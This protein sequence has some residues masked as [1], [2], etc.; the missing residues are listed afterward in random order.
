MNT[1]I[2]EPMALSSIEKYVQADLGNDFLVTITD[3]QYQSPEHFISEARNFKHVVKRVPYIPKGFRLGVSRIFVAFFWTKEE[4]G[5]NDNQIFSYFV[6]EGIDLIIPSELDGIEEFREFAN[7]PGINLL[8]Y[9]M[10]RREP[11]RGFGPRDVGQ[12]YLVSDDRSAKMRLDISSIG[13]MIKQMVGGI[14]VF[15][16]PVRYDG[17]YFRTMKHFKPQEFGLPFTVTSP[18]PEMIVERAKERMCA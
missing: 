15:S 17:E 3:R 5:G 13:S 7:V 14:A 4:H 6:P 10:V 11:E 16:D 12:I 18:T 8:P 9:D 1:G 2:F